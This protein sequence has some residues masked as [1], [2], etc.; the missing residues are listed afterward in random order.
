M[1]SLIGIGRSE[2]FADLNNSDMARNLM[3]SSS[4]LFSNSGKRAFDC[5]FTTQFSKSTF[6]PLANTRNR[7]SFSGKSSEDPLG[8]T[9]S[10]KPFGIGKRTSMTYH[11]ELN[12][13]FDT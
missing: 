6:I 12:N 11:R 1:E 13:C 3:G 8:V 4:N 2:S 5:D 10:T 7:H 9:S